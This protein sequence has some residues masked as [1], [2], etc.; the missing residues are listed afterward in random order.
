[1]GAMPKHTPGPWH[2]VNSDTDQP[3]DG[4]E[5]D[6]A[7]LRTVEEFGEDKTEIIDGKS[8]TSFRLPKFILSA[9]AFGSHTK[10]ECASNA[11]LIALAPELYEYV[12]SSAANGCATAKA[13]IN[14]LNN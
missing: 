13:L 2:W 7:S 14:K 11:R 5:F 4:D 9:E 3:I 10:E 6:F 12:A 8:Y 1:M